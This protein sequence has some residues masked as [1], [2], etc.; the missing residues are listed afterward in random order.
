MKMLQECWASTVIFIG[1]FSE[2]MNQ[3]LLR[4]CRFL[5]TSMTNNPGEIC[6]KDGQSLNEFPFENV[7]KCC[8]EIL[9]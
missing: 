6:S 9:F 1:I 4:F 8:V 7:F 5:Q 2:C 3:N